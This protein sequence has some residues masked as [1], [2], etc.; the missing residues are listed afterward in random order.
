[1]QIFSVEG[2]K[3]IGIYA[4][5]RIMPGEELSY[6]YKVRNFSAIKTLILCYNWTLM[7]ELH[8]ATMGH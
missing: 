3:H 2:T 1:M 4:K 6:D 8:A 7:S 5:R